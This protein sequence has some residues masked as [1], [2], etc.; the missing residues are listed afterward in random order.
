M[1]CVILVAEDE[2]MVRNL[3][4][5]VLQAEGHEVLAA[6][7]GAEALTLSRDYRGN[8]D[9]LITDV[10]M[11]RL[12]GFGLVRQILLERPNL[13]VLIMSGTPGD[14]RSVP[15]GTPFLQKP[16]QAAVLRD[17]VREMLHTGSELP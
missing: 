10:V 13:R 17:K 5:H 15:A 6:A 16:F 14:L 11:P 1:V 9:L 8:I 12:D 3:A 4:R 2:V 7:D